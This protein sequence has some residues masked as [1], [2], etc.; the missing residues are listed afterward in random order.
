M[1][2]VNFWEMYFIDRTAKQGGT[3]GYTTG[4]IHNQYYSDNSVIIVIAACGVSTGSC[5]ILG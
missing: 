4:K 5:S 3:N 2:L 1:A